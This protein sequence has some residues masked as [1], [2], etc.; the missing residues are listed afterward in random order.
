MVDGWNGIAVRSLCAWRSMSGW[1]EK[2]PELGQ[3]A[4]MDDQRIV[5]RTLLGGVNSLD[6]RAS[7][8]VCT[9]PV[10]GFGGECNGCLAVVKLRGGFT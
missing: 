10:D 5:R 6:S 8:C 7:C 3:R 2:A 4:D 9:E 1:Q